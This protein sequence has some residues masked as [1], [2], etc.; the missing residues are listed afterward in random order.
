MSKI[1]IQIYYFPS[2][3][4]VVGDGNGNGNGYREREE[5]GE[6]RKS[7]EMEKFLNFET[8]NND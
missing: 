6:G 2:L 1:H 4:W 8:V 5:R 7:K 3:V